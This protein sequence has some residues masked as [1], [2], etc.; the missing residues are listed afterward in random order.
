MLCLSSS[1]MAIPSSVR[2]TLILTLDT[3]L[4]LPSRRPAGLR[5]LCLSLRLE[6]PAEN[7]INGLLRLGACQD[8]ELLVIA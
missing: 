3:L 6:G 5:G 4:L 7:V 2:D 1:R 8:D